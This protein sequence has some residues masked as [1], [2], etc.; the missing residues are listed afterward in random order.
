M[1]TQDKLNNSF[2]FV[3]VHHP[4][5]CCGGC[6]TSWHLSGASVCGPNLLVVFR[7]RRTGILEIETCLFIRLML[8]PLVCFLLQFAIEYPSFLPYSFVSS[9]LR[10]QNTVAHHRFKPPNGSLPKSLE[11][12]WKAPGYSVGNITFW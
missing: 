3:G 5:P 7:W 1:P 8:S 11:F 10:Q 4:S 6:Q 2:P 9:V 12:T